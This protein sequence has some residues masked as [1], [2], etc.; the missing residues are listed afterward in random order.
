MSASRGSSRIK[1]NLVSKAWNT[2]GELLTAACRISGELRTLIFQKFHV[3]SHH[4]SFFKFPCASWLNTSKKPFWQTESP[5]IKLNSFRISGASEERGRAE[6]GE[7]HTCCSLLLNQ[8]D[9]RLHSQ[10]CLSSRTL[11]YCTRNEVHRQQK[12]ILRTG[13]ALPSSGM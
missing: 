11:P 9:L 2:Y 3:S 6:H 4:G 5:I 7:D 12:R 13:P 10:T 8:G 1:S